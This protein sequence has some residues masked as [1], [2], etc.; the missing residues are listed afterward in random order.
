MEEEL[1]Q[2]LDWSRLHFLGRIP[3]PHLLGLMQASWVHVYLSYPFV[4]GWSALEAMSCGCCLV[5][6]AGLPVEEVITNGVEGVLVP[7]DD[8]RRLA[9]RILVL[10]RRPDLRDEFSRRARA[11]ALQW[12]QSQTVPRL[13]ELILRTAGV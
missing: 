12:D 6:S 2:E 1:A 8:P 13:H 4:L 5:G 3:H 11:K 10:M 7:M 9:E